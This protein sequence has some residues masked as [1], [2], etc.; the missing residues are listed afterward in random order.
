MQDQEVLLKSWTKEISR[1]QCR[2]EAQ[3]VHCIAR[4]QQRIGEVIPYLNAVL[5]GDSFTADPPS[6]TFRSQGKLITIHDDHIAINALQDADEA[7]KIL[8]WL[9]KEINE[10]WANRDNITP[11]YQS[12][13]QPRVFEILK[14]LPRTNCGE[15]GQPTCMVFAGMVAE[16]GK[17]VDDCP[18][19]KSPEK[20]RLAS[21]L[22]NFN[23]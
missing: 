6:I 14:L 10:A 7:E 16:G 2:P 18:P 20:E 21:Y 23:L 19:L 22:S 17:G 9:Q 3:S 1:P 8:K 15:C 4:T 5:G 11:S 12:A 13:L